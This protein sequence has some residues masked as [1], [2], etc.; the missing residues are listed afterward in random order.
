MEAV[1]VA[2]AVLPLLASTIKHYNLLFLPFQTFRRFTT[3]AERFQTR[4]F[5]QRAIFRTQCQLLLSQVLEDSAAKRM[6]GDSHHP[7]WQDHDLDRSLSR[8]FG[9]AH[10]AITGVVKEIEVELEKLS[11]KGRELEIIMTKVDVS[12]GGRSFHIRA[13]KQSL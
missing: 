10:A 3:K 11:L 6:L 7:A 12:H 1:T 5:V 8:F 4:L 2:L 9:D 13:T